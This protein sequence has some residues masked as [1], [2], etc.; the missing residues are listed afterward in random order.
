MGEPAIFPD[1]HQYDLHRDAP[2][3]QYLQTHT[4]EQATPFRTAA[5]L[6]FCK[7]QAV[8]GNGHTNTT[9]ADRGDPHLVCCPAHILNVLDQMVEPA[10]HP[11]FLND[12][13][14]RFPGEAF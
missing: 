14:L 2:K 4:L 1:Q 6:A 10:K 9:L 13:A 12:P 7:E 5:V 11:L 3:G 8:T